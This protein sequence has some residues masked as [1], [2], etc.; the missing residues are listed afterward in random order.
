[1]SPTQILRVAQSS[2]MKNRMSGWERE[3]DRKKR[4]DRKEEE[5]K[6][7]ERETTEEGE[8]EA[9]REEGA[10]REE[11]KEPEGK[12]A[13]DAGMGRERQADTVTNSRVLQ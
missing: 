11:E 2:T 5:E 3:G 10:R 1:M 9:K 4:R 13:G 7:I 8:Q 6:G 12:S